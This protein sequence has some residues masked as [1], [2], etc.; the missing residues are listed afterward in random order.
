[1]QWTCKLKKCP[2]FPHLTIYMSSSWHYILMISPAVYI[3]VY[4]VDGNGRTVNTSTTLHIS[5]QLGSEN[6]H[7]TLLCWFIVMIWVLVCNNMYQY[8]HHFGSFYCNPTIL[9]TVSIKGSNMI[10]S[11]GSLTPTIHTQSCLIPIITWCHHF[12]HSNQY[13]AH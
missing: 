6:A 9:E 7:E 5:D 3:E 4:R 2:K 13:S 12:I 11:R 10:V 8:E 1:M